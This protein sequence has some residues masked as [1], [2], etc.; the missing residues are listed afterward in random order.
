MKNRKKLVE[1]IEEMR[2]VGDYLVSHSMPKVSKSEEIEILPLKQRIIVVDGYEVGVSF[3]KADY[4]SYYIE[5]FLIWGKTSKFLPFILT[6]K[7]ARYF[8]GQH[9]LTLAETFK[10]KRRIYCW[11]VTTDRD[12]RPLEMKRD[13]EECEFEGFKY[14]YLQPNQIK[15]F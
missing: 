10:D 2:G 13:A 11:S 5:T 9:E 6:S 4:G 15:F 3:S 8:L 1:I 7:L 12:G 14:R